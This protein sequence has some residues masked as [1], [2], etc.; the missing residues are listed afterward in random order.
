ME[1]GH[2]FEGR[3]ILMI[4]D[5]IELCSMMLEFFAGN[6]FRLEFVHDGSSGLART[7]DGKYDLVLLDVMLPM[8]DGFHVLEHLRRRTA[9]P[10]ILLTARS[11]RQDRITG[12]ESGADYYVCKPFDPDELLATVRAVLRR[13][14]Q[15][16][17]DKPPLIEIG[18]IRLNSRM[19]EVWKCNERIGVTS[20]EFD[21]L[22]VLMRSAG[23]VVSRDELSAVLYHRK[24]TPFEH[25]LEVHISHLRRKL[26]G[27]AHPLIRTVRGIGY[28]FVPPGEQ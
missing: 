2:S 26:E 18:D 5:D 19:R 15:T 28:L 8:L 13:A 23:R 3:S 9:I 10:V 22:D 1:H 25:S 17:A 7:L 24:S 6:D 20:A 16:F 12:L 27:A 4:D 14:G 21:I 11:A